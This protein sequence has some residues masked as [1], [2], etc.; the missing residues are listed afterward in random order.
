MTLAGGGPPTN[1]ESVP[2]AALCSAPAQAAPPSGRTPNRSASKASAGLDFPGLAA[3]EPDTRPSIRSGLLSLAS[4][5]GRTEREPIQDPVM[6]GFWS[7]GHRARQ[8]EAGR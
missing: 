5:Q 6:T 2:V 7:L 1:T 3:V 8:A 4:S